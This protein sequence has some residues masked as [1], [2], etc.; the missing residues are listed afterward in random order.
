MGKRGPQPKGHGRGSPCIRISAEDTA[1]LTERLPGRTLA[2]CI[3]AAVQS[4]KTGGNDLALRALKAEAEKCELEAELRRSAL[5]L[6]EK[7]RALERAR[8]TIRELN[9]RYARVVK[10]MP[11]KAAADMTLEPWTPKEAPDA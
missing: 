5:F 11:S 8:D 2:A 9:A 4:L 3:H 10:R 1:W 6:A 7:E